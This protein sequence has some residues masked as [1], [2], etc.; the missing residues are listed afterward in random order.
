MKATT[1]KI[2]KESEISDTISSIP[3]EFS[4]SVSDDSNRAGG[5]RF[6]FK[7]PY[8]PVNL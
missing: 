5:N 2:Q 7:I 8:K 4:M 3:S 1:A 6:N